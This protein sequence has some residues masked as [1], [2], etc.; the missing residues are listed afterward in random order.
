MKRRPAIR[1]RQVPRLK[2]PPDESVHERAG[3]VNYFLSSHR[4][5][6]S[7][8]QI[9]RNRGEQ[10]R[11]RIDARRERTLACE[12]GCGIHSYSTGGS[13]GKKLPAGE[14]RASQSFPFGR[15]PSQAVV[16]GHRFCRHPSIRISKEQHC[17][18]LVGRPRFSGCCS[19]SRA[20][21]LQRSCEPGLLTQSPELSGLLARSVQ[22]ASG[23]SSG[24]SCNPMVRLVERL[25][26][27][28]A[29]PKLM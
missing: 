18:M 29:D 2:V 9:G 4:S 25:I 19:L 27:L 21:H 26:D 8:L 10:A 16:S 3:V 24:R 12:H 13:G 20:L 23:A 11:A 22:L 7:R 6:P 14:L 1:G 5:R 17:S 28:S 15:S